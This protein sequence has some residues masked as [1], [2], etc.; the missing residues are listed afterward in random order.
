MCGLFA[1]FFRVKIT[2]GRGI[3]KDWEGVGMGTHFR[4][5]GGEGF[6]LHHSVSL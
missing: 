3:G 2:M 1:G 4:G 5:W 6:Q